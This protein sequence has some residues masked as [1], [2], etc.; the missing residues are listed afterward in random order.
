[1]NIVRKCS[2]CGKEM[3]E[4]YC[5]H[6]VE[7]YYCSDECLEQNMTHEEFLELYA[8]GEGDSYYTEW[9]EE[10]ESVERGEVECLSLF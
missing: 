5:I 4:G 3:N 10:D 9:E 2:Q 6:D 7:V 8:N 1:M